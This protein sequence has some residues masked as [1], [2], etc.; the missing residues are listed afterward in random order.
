MMVL[1]GYWGTSVALRDVISVLKSLTFGN[2]STS[3]WALSWNVPN[4][5]TVP[6]NVAHDAVQEIREIDNFGPAAATR[7]V[8]LV[9]PDCLVSVNS[10]SAD[11][12]GE[13]S[14]VAATAAGLADDYAELLQ[15]VHRQ[16]WFNAPEPDDALERKIW[17][18][19]AALLDAFV[20]PP[21][22]PNAD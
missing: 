1:L 8:T 13:L 18:S 14:N 17:R 16:D 22:N 12:L 19:R 2:K 4:D 10:Q 9:R 6:A 15:W 7:L 3:C 5:E 21:I 11:G 20:Y